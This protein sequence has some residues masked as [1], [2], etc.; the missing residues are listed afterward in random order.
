MNKILRIA[1]LGLLINFTSCKDMAVEKPDNLLPED[2]MIDI[3]YDIAI[4][5]AADN[6]KPINLS[7]A[8]V[9]VNNYIYKKYNIDSTTYYQNHKYYASDVNNYK[10]IY[11]KVLE[12][13]TA[14]QTS[15]SDSTS[16]GKQ[17]DNVEGI[18]K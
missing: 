9:K 12:K 10:K 1:I 8:G 3:I 4:L 16:I 11:K 13:I 6:Y 5:Q 7:D 14:E 17:T 2:K 18:V 15:L